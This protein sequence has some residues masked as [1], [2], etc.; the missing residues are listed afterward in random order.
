MWDVGRGSGAGFGSIECPYRVKDPHSSSLRPSFTYS[1][2]II[3]TGEGFSLNDAQRW[4]LAPT[5]Q[6]LI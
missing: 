5:S 4:S 2:T 6:P 3:F 1:L